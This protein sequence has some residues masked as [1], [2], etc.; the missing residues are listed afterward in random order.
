[1]ESFFQNIFDKINQVNSDYESNKI[2]NHIEIELILITNQLSESSQF[3]EYLISKYSNNVM[4]IYQSINFIDS[5]GNISQLSFIG[6]KKEI[7]NYK[8]SILI[9]PVYF[10]HN[11][12]PG[13]KLNIKL[14][15][16]N[17]KKD[18]IDAS[19]ARIK[20]RL[21]IN[22]DKNWRL[23][24][25]VVKNIDSLKYNQSKLKEYRNK[26]LVSNNVSN[27]LETS[28]WKESDNIEFE[29]EYIGKN[30]EL[31]DLMI[32]NSVFNFG[33]PGN[34]QIE[35]KPEINPTDSNLQNHEEFKK[36]L[37]YNIA[38][39][40]KPDLA[41]RFKKDYDLRQLG[42]SV[43]E[44]NKIM[45]LDNILEKITNY[46]ITDKVDGRRTMIYLNYNRESYAINNECKK[47]NIKEN[48][49]QDSVYIFDSEEYE[50]KYYIFDVLVW[51]GINVANKPF[52]ER[53]NIF[54]KIK[55][56]IL[57]IKPF[58]KLDH[59]YINTIKEF[60]KEE[61]KYKIDG[62]ILTPY[63]ESYSEMKVYKYKPVEHLTID[64]LI[65]KCP[66]SLLGISPYEL[67]NKNNT[68]YI[69]FCGISQSAFK[70]LKMSLIKNYSH[71]FPAINVRQLPKYFPIQ[72]EPSNK[73]FAYLFESTD[74][75]LDNKVGEFIKDFDSDIWKL[76]K[77][78]EDRI[79][80]VLNGNYFGNDYRFAELNWMSYEDPL[81]IE[82][83]TNNRYFKE[84]NDDLIVSRSFNNFVKSQIFNQLKDV[85]NV[86]DI[87]SGKG[88][89]LFR[90]YNVGVQFLTCTDIDI[91]ALFELINRKHILYMK[92][93]YNNKNSMNIK[94]AKIDVNKSYKK[95]INLLSQIGSYEKKYDFIVCDMAFHY[96]LESINTLK[97]VVSFIDYYLKPGGKFIFTALDGKKI[98]NILNENNGEYTI[99]TDNTKKKITK[100][101]N[102]SYI[103]LDDQL[104]DQLD[105]KLDKHSDKKIKYSIKKQFK[106]NFIENI[107]QPIDI[108]LPFS[109]DKYYKEFLVN[110][111]TIKEIFGSKYE[112]EINQSFGEY[113]KHYQTDD[114]T[115]KLNTYDI[116]YVSLYHY[117][118]F[119][120]YPSGKRI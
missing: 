2:N 41:P 20:N 78:R 119:Y 89:D 102:E 35:S 101:T 28:N 59:D 17:D 7:V 65:K 25:T 32:A 91:D 14:E 104:D 112:L 77:I 60:K 114:E 93:N 67:K 44:L 90:Y 21:S 105:D 15:E 52:Y 34:V 61:K 38:K 98:I 27:F 55:N 107:G 33:E 40:I 10:I 31:S 72:F 18:I 6:D 108:K 118:R 106:V 23:D 47:I 62:I 84:S 9:K 12:L 54:S 69:L 117:Y 76:I 50:N 92:K 57:L 56:D 86:F 3:C 94:I 58:I 70:I 46:Y 48:T 74:D 87:A 49:F 16:Y 115:K 29:L 19:F 42:N 53:L 88:Q 81:I 82:D 109:K 100:S 75:S 116:E 103:K 63:D 24:I 66:T 37:L 73:D 68:L 30:I 43:I 36:E 8:K 71:I 85:M 97:N 96:F 120:K 1:M 5:V 22:I 39:Y 45:Y 13:Y 64:F 26:F 80:S 51:N 111:D 4:N 83:I 95:N 79:Q 11:I 99:Y 110:I 113:I